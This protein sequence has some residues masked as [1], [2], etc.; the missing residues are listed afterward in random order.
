M[1]LVA[2]MAANDLWKGRKKEA[3]VY[4]RLMAAAVH[5]AD[6]ASLAGR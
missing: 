2:D 3:G 1:L 5:C 6:G 4:G